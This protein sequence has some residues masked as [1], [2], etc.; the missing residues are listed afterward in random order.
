M[1]A[2]MVSATDPQPDTRR[3]CPAEPA[4]TRSVTI[5]AEPGAGVF[6]AP[7]PSARMRVERPGETEA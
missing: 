5:Q 7:D 4:L 1:E 2:G 6:F 3:R